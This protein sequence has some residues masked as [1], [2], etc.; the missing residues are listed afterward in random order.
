M[1]LCPTL[2]LSGKEL[3]L[4]RQTNVIESVNSYTIWTTF[5]IFTEAIFIPTDI[6]AFTP[7][8][9]LFLFTNQFVYLLIFFEFP[10]FA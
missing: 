8:M 10:M 1:V 7:L 2:P 9:Y 6:N 5:H 4:H 3:L